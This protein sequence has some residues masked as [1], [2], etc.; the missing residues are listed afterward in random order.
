[1]QSKPHKSHHVPWAW[2]RL[3][4]HRFLAS[5]AQALVLMLVRLVCFSPMRISPTARY[6]VLV[7]AYTQYPSRYKDLWGLRYQSHLAYARLSL[8]ISQWWYPALLRCHDNQSNNQNVFSHAIGSPAQS[9]ESGYA[10]LRAY[11]YTVRCFLAH[12]NPLI[13]YRRRS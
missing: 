4:C 5:A 7:A 12:Q 10:A 8:D 9:P 3:L 6:V 1:M 11:R 13:T 2:S